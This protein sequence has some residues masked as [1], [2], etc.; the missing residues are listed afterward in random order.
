[1]AE[2]G[3]PSKTELVVISDPAAYDRLRA[4]GFLPDMAAIEAGDS[5]NE[6]AA[7]EVVEMEVVDESKVLLDKSSAAGV[8]LTEKEAEAVK[9]EAAENGSGPPWG[10]TPS[11]CLKL[12]QR[13]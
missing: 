9:E 11:W 3:G 1:M 2:N 10:H 13:V 8:T 4:E 12:I 7:E 5:L 6:V